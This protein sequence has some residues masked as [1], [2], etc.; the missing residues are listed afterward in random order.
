MRILQG[1][2]L[3]GGTEQ[4][5]HLSEMNKQKYQKQLKGKLYCPTEECPALISYSAG[6]KAH[7]KTWRLRHHSPHCIYNNKRAVITNSDKD[8]KATISGN[9]RQS[10]L[11]SAA[12]MFEGS[13]SEKKSKEE[14]SIA[15]R[16]AKRQRKNSMQMTLYDDGLLA[17]E[18][19]V[20]RGAIRKKFVDEL[21]MKDVGQVRLVLG[22]I[23]SIELV[24]SVAELVIQYNDRQVKV[25]YPEAFIKERLNSS[26]LN[27]F[28]AIY[29]VL[30][31]EQPPTFIGI[32][33]I[34][35]NDEQAMELIIYNG[36][37]FTINN[38]DLSL[39]AKQYAN[40]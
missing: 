34:G 11:R 8:T 18:A 19:L 21:T 24:D 39:F 35:L 32:G 13:K 12:K 36:T 28:D 9:R 27:K 25:V 17:E 38:K 40:E 2:Y 20:K 22:Y 31:S 7:F 23:D 37:D 4:V 10:A 5:V 33:Q 1:R 29:K 16:L 30:E 3:V 26:Y 15:P 14:Q 6:K